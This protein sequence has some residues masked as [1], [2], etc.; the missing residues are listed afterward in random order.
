MAISVISVSPDSSEESV[1]TSAARVILFSTIPTTIPDTTPIV[2]SP[3]THIDTT[4]IPAE[5][6]TVLPI[7]SPSLDYTPA[8]NTE[9]NPFED[10]SLD[11]I[12]PLP[13]TLPFL[14]STDDSSNSDTPDTPP[15]PPM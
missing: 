8:F 7:I 3:A 13:A 11:R 5:I 10:P 6:P 4:L 1:G 12:P 14:S 9:S 2:T 15:S